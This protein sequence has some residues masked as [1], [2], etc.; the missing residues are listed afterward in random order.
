MIGPHLAKVVDLCREAQLHGWSAQCHREMV[1]QKTEFQG[2][3]VGSHQFESYRSMGQTYHVDKPQT[4]FL[5]I[6]CIT[7][8]ALEPQLNGDAKPK[9]II[10][11]VD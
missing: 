1:F 9:P 8:I 3:L 11:I 6:F 7:P 5:E 10:R 2:Q 4:K